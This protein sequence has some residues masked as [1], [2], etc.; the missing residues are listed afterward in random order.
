MIQ[1]SDIR[2]FLEIVSHGSFSEAARRM[3]IPKSTVTRQIDRLEATLGAPLFRRT[4]RQVV[5]TSEGREFLPRAKRLLDDGME[6][7]NILRSQT[8][9]AYGR[10]LISATG[11]IAR[12]FMVPYLPAFKRR[13]PQ[14]EVALWLTPGRMEVG[15]DE[16]QV[17]IAIRLRSSAGPGLATRKLGEIP[18]WLV[19]SPDYIAKHGSPKTPDDLKDHSLV[20]L[21]PP[22]K[23][24]QTDLLRGKEVATIRYKPWLQIDDPEAVVEAARAGAGVA[25]V[26]AF[27]AAP[28][29]EAGK[30]ERVLEAWA[31]APV[32]INVLYRTDTSPPMRVKAYVDYL[33]ETVGQEQPWIA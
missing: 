7:E 5:L 10:L 27:A 18:F 33:F 2:V 23:A 17:E 11:L 1:L 3:K 19:A 25:I 30:L 21:G 16:G 29:V 15:H 22:N 9:G 12:Q 4:T 14:L 8:I 32:P 28:V 26:P 24:H 6:A 13:H 20:E 31:P